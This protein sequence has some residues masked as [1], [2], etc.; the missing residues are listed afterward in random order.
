[1]SRHRIVI[2]F[3]GRPDAAAVANGLERA[4]GVLEGEARV[5]EGG[6][7]KVSDAQVCARIIDGFEAHEFLGEL[8]WEVR[9]RG[10]VTGRLFW[11]ISAGGAGAHL[12]S[13]VLFRPK[14]TVKGHG[15]TSAAELASFAGELASCVA[16]DSL[17]IEPETLPDATQASRLADKDGNYILPG[18][19][20]MFG[21]APKWVTPELESK[22]SPFSSVTKPQLKLWVLADV[23]VD[24]G[25][26]EGLSTLRQAQA[27]LAAA[28]VSPPF[29]LASAQEG[30]LPKRTLH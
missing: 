17:I 9:A 12:E 2:W 11:P 23:P 21:L 30:T 29:V 15:F 6:S 25:S 14:K 20:W 13:L 27:A 24:A 5:F 26:H 22:L 16:A 3:N 10:A 7:S 19:D 28:A 18:A 4:A 1:M 8:K